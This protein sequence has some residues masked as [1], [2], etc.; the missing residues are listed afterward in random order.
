MRRQSVK[1][2]GKVVQINEL[3]VM[4]LKALIEKVGADFLKTEF[5]AGQVDYLDA[6]IRFLQNHVSVVF[7]DLTPEDIENAYPSE[8][9]ALVEGFVDVNFFGVRR[10]AGNVLEFAERMARLN[11][12]PG[13]GLAK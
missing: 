8:I 5:G 6:G 2:A 13:P 4:E 11:S 10:I 1:V 9:E 3:R 7:P 12:G